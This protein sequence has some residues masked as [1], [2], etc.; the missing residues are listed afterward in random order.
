MTMDMTV[1][2]PTL[3]AIASAAIG[4]IV[5]L[6][7][8]ES[9]VEATKQ[10]LQSAVDD[11]EDR[12]TNEELKSLRETVGV[13]SGMLNLLREQFHEYQL[14][15]AQQYTTANTVAEIKREII[16][17]IG[18]MEQRVEAQINRLVKA[19]EATARR[20]RQAP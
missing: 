3:F 9:R 11:I 15:V 12:A 8:L 7:K 4:F 17:E 6:V 16:V 14:A 5:W 1:N 10:A 19:P 2:V 18:K 20:N 13:M